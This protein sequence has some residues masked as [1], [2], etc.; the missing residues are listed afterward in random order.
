M[1]ADIPNSFL[2]RDTAEAYIYI[3]HGFIL[4]RIRG[5]NQIY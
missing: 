2:N 1:Q 5:I 4:R 3:I